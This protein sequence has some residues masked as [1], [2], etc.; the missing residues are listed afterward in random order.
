MILYILL[1]ENDTRNCTNTLLI[2]RKVCISKSVACW[3]L[4]L[5]GIVSSVEFSQFE[6]VRLSAKRFLYENSLSG[7]FRIVGEVNSL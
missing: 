4:N 2:A 7:D 6:E 1:I 5:F 3:E